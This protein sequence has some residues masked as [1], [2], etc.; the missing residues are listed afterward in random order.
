MLSH[1]RNPLAER[2]KII[3][4]FDTKSEFHTIRRYELKKKGI[5]ETELR[6]SLHLLSSVW[7]S[8]YH[9]VTEGSGNFNNPFYCNIGMVMLVWIPTICYY[10]FPGCK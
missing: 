9:L 7:G 6:G 1:L 10:L 8:S 2:N 5:R 3:C 4:K